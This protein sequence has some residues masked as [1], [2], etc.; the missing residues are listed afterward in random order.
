MEDSKTTIAI[1]TT[2]KGFLVIDMS[3]QHIFHIGGTGICD[4]CCRSVDEYEYVGALNNAYC[5]DCFDEWHRGAKYYPEDA[6]V[7]ERRISQM[8]HKLSS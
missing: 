5:A 2:E 3:K 1:R 6:A 4:W 8:I 7:E